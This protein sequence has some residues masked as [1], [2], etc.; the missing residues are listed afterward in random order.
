MEFLLGVVISSIL[1]VFVFYA[2]KKINSHYP[3]I[4][5]TVSQ[6]RTHFMYPPV[7]LPIRERPETQAIRH[8]IKTMTRVIFTKQKAYWIQ[9]NALYEADIENG[10]V[11]ED[12][13]KVV[14]TMSMDKVQLD[15]MMFIV[16][17][18]TEGNSIDNSG[19]GN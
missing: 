3:S 6:S 1:T 14:D 19:S 5:V 15:E 17:K 9:D 4:K 12:S 8:S 16:Q 18:L 10:L 11:V 2:S 13:T 7:I